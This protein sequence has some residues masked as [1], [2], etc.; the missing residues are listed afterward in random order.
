MLVLCGEFYVG[1]GERKEGGRNEEEGRKGEGGRKG[2]GEEGVSNGRQRRQRQ[3]RDSQPMILPHH[4]FSPLSLFPHPFSF[5]FI[6]L[7]T[8]L[9]LNHLRPLAFQALQ[10]PLMRPNVAL[11]SRGRGRKGGKFSGGVRECGGEGCEGG[12][13]CAGVSVSE[14]RRAL[15]G[16]LTHE[17][18]NKEERLRGGRKRREGR[19]R[20]RGRGRQDKRRKTRKSKHSPT[21]PTL[22]PPSPPP[23]PASAPPLSPSL[24][25][26]VPP[27]ISSRLLLKLVLRVGKI[28]RLWIWRK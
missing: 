22:S 20:G 26:G 13:L 19:G 3:R 14:R 17:K 4:L 18:K 16:L 9:S 5:S 21:P 6:T 8:L 11:Q 2:W 27:P 1:S 12:L 28:L 15:V 23:S 7:P 10:L 25:L 24:P